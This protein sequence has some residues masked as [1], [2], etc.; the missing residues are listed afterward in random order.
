MRGSSDADVRTFWRKKLR[1]FQN[2]WCVRTDK[3][4]RG[5][6]T[7]RTF[8]GQEE[9]GSIF[10]D[11]LRTSFM[12]G[13]LVVLFHLKKDKNFK[14]DNCYSIHRLEKI[15]CSLR[16]R[17]SFTT[18]QSFQK[19]LECYDWLKKNQSRRTVVCRHVG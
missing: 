9:R 2:L 18:N 6:E 3:G 1:I 10:R 11:F 14:F 12:D 13:H 8:F 17:N 19:N 15:H 4:G 7:V 16:E 5:I